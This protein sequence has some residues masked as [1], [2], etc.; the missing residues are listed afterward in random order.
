VGPEDGT[1]ERRDL[2][3]SGRAFRRGRANAV[4]A[5]RIARYFHALGEGASPPDVGEPTLSDM[6][7]A[8][9]LLAEAVAVEVG[10]DGNVEAR[11]RATEAVEVTADLLEYISDAEGA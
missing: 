9:A 7:W 4:Q 2:M 8:L 6:G 5:Q 11:I 3:A 10:R 1:P